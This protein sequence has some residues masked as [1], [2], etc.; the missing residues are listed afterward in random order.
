MPLPT[1][2]RVI[3]DSR[4]GKYLSK[5][6]VSQ[7]RFGGVVMQYE[8]G[9]WRSAMGIPAERAQCVATALWPFDAVQPNPYSVED[10][11]EGSGNER[12]AV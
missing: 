3:C 6:T 10:Y 1:D 4:N 2:M 11:V 5:L 12:A 9:H 7:T 8:F